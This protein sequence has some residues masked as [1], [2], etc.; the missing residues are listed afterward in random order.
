[1]KKVTATGAKDDYGPLVRAAA[2]GDER[3][4]D[5]LLTR[6]QEVARR[7]SLAVCGDETDAEDALQEALLKTY[8]SARQIRDAN[9]FRPWLYRIVR[10]ACLLS[11]RRRVDEPRRFESLDSSG[12]DVAGVRSIDPADPGRDPEQLV[13][14]A[15]RRA[16]LRVA[17]AAIPKAYRTVLFLRDMEGLSTREVARVLRIS[18]DNVKTRLKRARAAL[19]AEVQKHGSE[20]V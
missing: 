3:A 18:E 4:M 8:R 10:N 5:L 11:R 14:E 17:L 2:D 19:R 7:F 16:R 20:A 12:G 13:E 6:A 9:A 15:R 1:V